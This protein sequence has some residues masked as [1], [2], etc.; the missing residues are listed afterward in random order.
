VNDCRFIGSHLSEFQKGELR[1]I[2]IAT[3]RE[4]LKADSMRVLS[5]DL[6]I[7]L[8]FEL[9]PMHLKLFGDIETFDF[10]RD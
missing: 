4:I 3:M 9:G 5:E 2:D 7:N 6:L 8:I 10:I 1:E